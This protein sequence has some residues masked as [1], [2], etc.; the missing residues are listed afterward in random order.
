MPRQKAEC[1]GTLPNMDSALALFD[2]QISTWFD[3]TYGEPTDI[4][5]QAWPK[6]ADG[7]HLLITAPTGS[8]KTLTAFLWA[9][10]QFLTK[11]LEPGAT[12]ILYVSP[13]KALNNDIQRNLTS[14]LRALREQAIEAG[15]WFPDI[16]AQTRSGDTDQAERRRMLRHPPEIL[17][18]TPESLNILLT[19]QSGQNLLRHIETV[20]LDE[21]HGVVDDKRGVYL[22]SAIERIVPLAGEF[23]RISL[24]AT[25]NPMEAVAKFVAGFEKTGRDAFKPRQVTCL[26]SEVEKRYEVSVRYPEA[27]AN[28]PADEKI[29][30]SLAEDFVEKIRGNTSTLLFVNSRALAENLTH[31]INTAAQETLAYAHHGSLSREIRLEVEQKLKAGELAAIVATGTLE[32]GIDIGALDEVVLIQAP[33]GVASAIQRIGRAGHGV[34]EVSRCT[35]YPTHPLD[36]IESAVLGKAVLDKDIE[37]IHTVHCPLDVLAQVIISMASTTTWDIDELYYEIRRATAFQDLGRPQYDLIISML[38][39]RYGENRIRE[40]RPRVVVDQLANTIEARKGSTMSLYLS[41]GVIPDRGYFQLRHESNNAKIGELD[42]EF[43][44]EAYVG[45]VFAFGTQHWKIN[46]ITHNDVV[47]TPTQPS[48][49]APPFWTSE[50][51]NRSFHYA[52]RIADFLEDADEAVDTPDYIERLQNEHHLEP[53]LSQEL[54]TL[55][56]RQKEH[57]NAPLPHRHHILVEY[58]QSAPGQAAGTQLVIHTGWGNRV[59]RPMAL[60]MEAAWFDKYAEQPEIFVS[61]QCLV[62]QLLDETDTGNLL[63]L[64]NSHNVEQYLRQRLEGS[65][66]FGARF[67]E[68][69]GR[70]LLLSKGK[71]NERKPLWMSR[72]QSQKLLDVV[73]KYEDFPILLETWRSCLQ[74][75]FDM[76]NLHR[77]LDELATGEISVTEVTTERPS[78]FAQTV[79]WDQVNEYMYKRDD[80]RTTIASNLSSDLIESLVFQPGLRPSIPQHVIDD[81]VLRRQR[82]LSGY[83]PESELELSEW[84]KE[85][86]LIPLSEWWEDTELPSNLQVL[87]TLGRKFVIATEDRDWI[88]E[89]LSELSPTLLSNWLQYYGPLTLE[90]VTTLLGTEPTATESAL[91]RLIGDQ[92]II[93]GKLVKDSDLIYFCDAGNFEVLLRFVRKAARIQF[94]PLPLDALTPFLYRWQRRYLSSGNKPDT[95][96]D[97]A[98]TLDLLQCL[99]A[100]PEAWEQSILPARLPG[101]DTRHLDLAMQFGAIYW[102]GSDKKVQFCF[103]EVLG[104]LNSP[105]DSDNGLIEDE[106]SRYD[107]MTLLDKTGLPAA[108]LADKL[109]QQVWDMTITNDSFAALRKGIE[110]KFSMS[111]ISQP[112]TGRSMRRTSF[113]NWQKELPYAGNW[114][115]PRFP[116]PSTDLLEIEDANRERVRL[117]FDRYGVLFRELLQYER[118]EFRWPSIFKTLRLMELSGEAQSGYFF[119]GVPGPQFIS[120][121][122]LTALTANS[123]QVFWINAAD[124]ISLSGMGLPMT[125][126]RRVAS[127]YLVFRGNNI[128]LRIEQNGKKLYTS[129]NVTTE[130]FADYL[131]VFQHLLNRSWQPLKQIELEIIND[132]P[133]RESEL[134]NCFD[135]NF[136]VVRDHRSVYLQKQR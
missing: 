79:A 18:T 32:M 46:K 31:K 105:G 72:L 45:K 33:E 27:A 93:A 60:A 50:G 129:D 125:L 85:R 120:S 101:Y 71:F 2:D 66:F 118:T 69:A 121:N 6:I 117:L 98:S 44:W 92:T 94:E 128:K 57:T 34:G 40:L 112:A 25:V 115:K 26:K 51:I 109:W 15:Q 58:I 103:A 122:A 12:R 108:D 1:S 59:N 10:N 20:I 37:P 78:P 113:R 106:F 99:P 28:R 61:D 24:S 73:L 119:D 22:M 65:G 100:N 76:P 11:Q 64:I 77:V 110:N 56:Q 13:L 8:G 41:G 84:V 91:T 87:E 17:I 82:K 127:N 111:P 14:P 96:A 43:V 30:E 70:A 135:L 83:E 81:F 19:S 35:I 39:G 90:D 74:D 36:F 7:E 21:V 126:P 4:Q 88:S 107:F 102:L 104:L 29:W 53:G 95:D 9:I 5:K 123:N 67:R 63:E 16:R 89:N 136:D 116:E 52:A 55:L 3:D 54:V 49:I 42:E 97:L 47:V 80:P 133:I 134:L 86:M 75:E 114:F 48:T 62:V 23:Q 131:G 132:S 68:N 130:E 38:N 124:P